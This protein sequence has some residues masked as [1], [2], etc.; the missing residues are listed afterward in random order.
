MTE[1]GILSVS[2]PPLNPFKVSGLV[3]SE[4]FLPGVVNS[5]QFNKTLN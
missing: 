3:L 4:P 2:I 5:L 1:N